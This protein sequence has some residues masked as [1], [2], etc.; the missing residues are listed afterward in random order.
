MGKKNKNRRD[1]GYDV[2]NNPLDYFARMDE[3]LTG[4]RPAEQLFGESFGRDNLS[5]DID[6]LIYKRQTAESS[7]KPPKK[8]MIYFDEALVSP[9]IAEELDEMEETEEDTNDF[10]FNNL[11]FVDDE[12]ESEE[13]VEDNE[14]DEI[15]E[16]LN[17]VNINEESVDDETMIR[18]I[19]F[20]YL[21]DFDRLVINDFIAPTSFS[22]EYGLDKFIN[23]NQIDTTMSFD[24]D[25]VM[26]MCDT[27]INYIVSLKHPTAIYTMEDFEKKFK[28]VNEMG[29]DSECFRFMVHD[30]FNVVLAYYVATDLLKDLYEVFE[31]H[32][33]DSFDMLW[34]LISIA[35]ACGSINDAFFVENKKY[36]E[37]FMDSEYNYDDELVNVFNKMLD[38]DTDED[39]TINP[40]LSSVK[41]IQI[42]GRD[43]I[44]KLTGQ[45]Y[46]DNDDDE[47]DDDVDQL[48][49]DLDEEE[50]IDDD[51][52]EEPEVSKEAFEEFKESRND[53]SDENDLM[54]DD[55][56]EV[57]EEE[58]E[59][60]I[61]DVHRKTDK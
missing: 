57:S 4:K 49:E 55:M 32:S 41:D 1:S 45:P 58:T 5:D 9:E 26:A 42:E 47:D 6:A 21:E 52:D 31:A 13:V 20:T 34:S 18:S 14:E 22:F 29:Y 23:P 8:D 15:D 2:S 60:L 56:E 11:E 51:L 59:K 17:Q 12:E 7:K 3:I 25:E 48:M 24:S 44:S 37:T 16:D 43:L 40:V 61:V 39:D 50:D 46:F 27:L 35:N 33:M 28:V 10:S 19:D 54:D 53:E 30:D 38:G 36:I